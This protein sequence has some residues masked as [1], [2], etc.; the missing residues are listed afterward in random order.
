MLLCPDKIWSDGE[1]L[2]NMAVE[3]DG[4]RVTAL[5]PRAA[6]DRGH[7]EAAA[8]FLLMPGCTDIQVNGGGGVM[9]NSDPTP[10]GLR[11]IAEAHAR[12]GS[13]WIL[14]TVI[15]DRPEVTQAAAEAVMALWPDPNIL[16]LH[17]EGPH[18]APERRGTHDP[19]LI[20]PLDRGTVDLVA[21][22]RAQG[23][24]VLL[25]LAPERADRALLAELKATGCVIS[26]GHT[27]ANTAEVKQGLADG[28]SCF[29]HLYN[30]M[31]PMTSREP[32]PVGVAI[33]SGAHVGMIADGI[34]VSWEMARIAC[35]ARPRPRR[36]F[37]VSDAM[38]TV[39]GP[40][41]FTLYGQK[42][43]VKDGALVNA[44]GSLAGAH[45]DLVTSLA[46]AHVHIGLPLAEA[47]A[48]C[49]DVP[50]DVLG[51]PRQTIAPGTPLADLICLDQ[52]L[53]LTEMPHG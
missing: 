14:P 26:A 28:I 44:E 50:R 21:R 51:L 32:G 20:R 10:E 9:L 36:H 30:A 37:L 25:T 19:A 5:R 8:P 16:G 31:P 38:A 33:T 43:H 39:G 45:I 12:L 24:P 17:I 27:A 35:A 4:T 2:T 52:H 40:D 29:T 15:T 53:A 42:I 3:T 46:N 41:H 34:H 13:R 11:R 6:G 48:M 47:V 7:D 18:I 23:I 22:L 1:L 49:T